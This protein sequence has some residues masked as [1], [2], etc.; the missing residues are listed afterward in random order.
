MVVQMAKAAGA[1][2]A[3]T[4]GSAAKAERARRLGADCVINYRTD[5]LKARLVDFAGET[6]INV[7]Y[8]TQREQDFQ[9]ILP[10]MAKRGRIVVM[11]G[12][13]AQPVLP[14]G[15]FYPKDLSLHGFAMF[16]A[17]PQE[18]SACAEDINRWLSAG[19]LAVLIGE[20]FAL[21]DT[22]AAQKLQED[23]TLHHAGS[24]IGKIVVTP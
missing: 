5:D 8:E 9:M 17:T 11:A 20:T 12:R 16:N 14:I 3:T 10:L 18:Q 21:R 4:V 24:L 13:Q 2:V 7:W 19:K 15:Q 1:K 6:G 22:V 23:N